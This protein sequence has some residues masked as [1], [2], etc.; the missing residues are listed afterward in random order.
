[1][2]FS[3]F[4]FSYFL[5]NKLKEQRSTGTMVSVLFISTPTHYTPKNALFLLIE[6]INYSIQNRTSH[7]QVQ[8][9]LRRLK[10][11]E[12]NNKKH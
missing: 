6:I 2:N 1:M 7:L 12:Y 10:F 4:H 11:P 3:S 8:Y 9:N 5:P